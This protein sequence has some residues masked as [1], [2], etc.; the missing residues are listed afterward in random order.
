MVRSL[1][2]VSTL[3]HAVGASV[4]DFEVDGGAKAND[5]SWDA[6]WSNGAALNATLAKLQP[7]DT[8]VV[9]AKK[10]YIM[11]GIQARD[12]RN[13]T[14]SVDGTLE[15]ASTALNALR[16]INAWPRKGNGN[17]YE[18]IQF[19]N[20]TNVRFTSA[21]EGTLD[22]SGAKWWGIPGIGYLQR[23]ENRPRLLVIS[24]SSDI[25]V[26]RLFFKGVQRGLDLWLGL[27]FTRRLSFL[28]RLLLA[29]VAGCCG[30][31]LWLVLRLRL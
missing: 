2:V 14:I 10:F 16:Y 9:P 24:H 13:V 11:G 17:V 22:G 6:V 19:V 4:I 7:G 3:L 8:F 12:L 25:L 30:W 27:L 28:L 23:Q 1:A 26:E 20:F 21:T 31:L 18:C 5:N 29:A 15:F